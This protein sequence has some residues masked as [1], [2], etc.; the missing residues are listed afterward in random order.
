M[1]ESLFALCSKLLSYRLT[2]GTFTFTVMQ[3]HVGLALLA[4]F[5]GAIRKFF[6]D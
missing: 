3:A 6:D 4:I 5:L 2:F 1:F